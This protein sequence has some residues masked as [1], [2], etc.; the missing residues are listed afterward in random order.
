MNSNVNRRHNGDSEGCRLGRIG[1]H[2]HIDRE[3]YFTGYNNLS[4]LEAV[5]FLLAAAR[6]NPDAQTGIQSRMATITT[7]VSDLNHAALNCLELPPSN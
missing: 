4:Q 6:A 2:V 5:M 3:E 1:R 7:L